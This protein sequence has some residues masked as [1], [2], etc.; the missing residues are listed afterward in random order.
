MAEPDWRPVSGGGMHQPVAAKPPYTPMKKVREFQEKFL[1]KTFIEEDDYGRRRGLAVRMELIREEY[2]EAMDE[3]L[4]IQNGDGSIFRTAKE[5]ADLL[6][7][8]Y[9]AAVFLE[10][11]LEEAFEEVHRSNMSKLGAD[12]KPVLRKDGKILKGPNYSE[13]NMEKVF[14]VSD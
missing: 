10:I 9:G 2:K 5:L 7:V 1:N 4:D 14:G 11:P 6:Y 13:A 8:V 12:G 3:L